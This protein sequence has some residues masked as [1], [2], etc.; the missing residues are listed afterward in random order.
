MSLLDDFERVSKA[1][2]CP[3]CGKQGWCLIARDGTEAVCQRIESGRRFGDAGWAHSL[4][5]RG[6]TPVSIGKRIRIIHER[7]VRKR[8]Q[9]F[10]DMILHGAMNL[11]RGQLRAFGKSLGIAPGILRRL[12]VAWSRAHRAWMFAMKDGRGNVIGIRLRTPSGRK[13]AVTGSREGLFIPSDLIEGGPLLVCEGPTDTA[14]ML[15]LRFDAIGRPSCTGGTRMIIDY[16]RRHCPRAIALVADR[17]APGRRGAHRLAIEIA[18]H[19]RDVRVITPPKGIKDAREWLGAGATR[20]DVLAAI[21]AAEPY[22]ISVLAILKPAT[23]KRGE[24]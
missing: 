6:A 20:Q 24:L 3:V 11:D 1:K 13:F 23:K 10:R 19:C 9:R 14:A 17:D 15:Q 5:R 21:A 22:N 12:D 4:R 16:I 8:D 2:P 7:S 18:L